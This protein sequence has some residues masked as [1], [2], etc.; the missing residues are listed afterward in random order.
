MGQRANNT[1]RI[2]DILSQHGRLPVPVG[3]LHD[4]SDLYNAGLTSLASVGLMLAL[5][6]RVGIE[7]RDSMLGRSTFRSMEA[8]AE[9]VER[10][11]AKQAVQAG[12]WCAADTRT[13]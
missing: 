13:T 10:L 9:A 1:Q 8:I 2:R 4:N 11:R 3:Q 12:E 6:D 7:L 5:E